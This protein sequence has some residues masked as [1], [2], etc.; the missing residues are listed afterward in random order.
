M[1]PIESALELLI[2]WKMSPEN[3]LELDDDIWAL[4]TLIDEGHV[5]TAAIVL[6]DWDAN[7]K[8]QIISDRSMPYHRTD[9]RK[10]PEKQVIANILGGPGGS[11][12]PGDSHMFVEG[13]VTIQ[14]HKVRPIYETTP[15]P[16]VAALALIVPPNTK[17]FVVEIPD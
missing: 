17:G 3:R 4:R 13:A 1:V 5:T 14:I 2:D 16:V 6:M 10:D 15:N 12:Y 11:N 8:S 9:P 7:K